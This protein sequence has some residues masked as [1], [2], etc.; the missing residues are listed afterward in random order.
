MK[1]KFLNSSINKIKI[2]YPNY[3]EEKLE[4]IAYG[5]EAIYLTFT[6]TIFIFIVAIILHI[7]KEMFILMILY[8][9]LRTTAFGMHAKK[10]WHCLIISTTMFIG[11]ALFIKY[12]DINIYI[13]FIISFIS[14]IFVII[15]APA[16]TYKRPLINKKKRNI[17]KILSIIISTIYVILIVIFRNNIISTYLMLGLLESTLMI[18]PLTYRMFHLPYANYKT[19]NA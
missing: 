4:E 10:S 17:Y 19:Y 6:K 5:L 1:E 13:K 11:G 16:D 14:Y 7:F 12:V 8:N 15:Y 18:H 2:K 3:S 9:I